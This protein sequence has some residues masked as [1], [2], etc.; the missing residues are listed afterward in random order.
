MS[1]PSVHTTQL[2]RWLEGIRG[3]NPAARDE[4][5]R[6]TC[7]H[8]ERLTSKMLRGFPNVRRHA[9]TDDVLQNSLMRLLRSLERVQPP[10]M[11]DFYNL[12]AALIRSELLDLARH[13]ARVNRH[14]VPPDPVNPGDSD[15]R[16]EPPDRAD[17]PVELER[18]ERFHEAWETLPADEREVV[19][20]L[21]YQGRTQAEAAELFGVTVRTVQRR[22]QAAMLKLHALLQT[23]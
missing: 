20:L 16:G 3:G 22:W 13:F 1:D 19:G 15:A 12:A 14:E 8:L 7:G 6:A 18:W 5:L 10:S 4:L 21:F 17:D 2:Q 9:Q 23:E 11:R